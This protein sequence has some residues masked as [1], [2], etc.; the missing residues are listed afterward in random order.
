[1]EATGHYWMACFSFLTSAGYA[2]CVVNPM[3]VRAV[4][5]LK[6]M[7][8]VKNDRVDSWLIAETLKMGSYERTRLAD[9]DV[10]ALRM[11]TRYP[12]VLKARTRHR[13]DPVHLRDGRVLSRVR[14]AVLKHGSGP[15]RS[16]FSPPNP[17]PQR[18]PAHMRKRLPR[19]FLLRREGALGADKAAELKAAGQIVGGRADRARGRVVP[20]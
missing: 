14:R 1:M 5:E 19:R 15:P 20:G 11:L 6:S 7:P 18:S 2:C 8:R 9:D 17:H 10:Q 3:Q 13:E 4:R 12:A 16:R